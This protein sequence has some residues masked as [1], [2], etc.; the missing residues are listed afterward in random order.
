MCNGLYG[1]LV[2]LKNLTV[3]NSPPAAKTSPGT[4]IL[5]GGSDNTTY[6]QEGAAFSV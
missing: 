3:R 5:S 4:G 6:K 2:D 1:K